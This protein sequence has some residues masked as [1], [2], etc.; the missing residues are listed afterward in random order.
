[1]LGRTLYHGDMLLLSSDGLHG[2]LDTAAIESVLG[3]APDVRSAA[4]TLV[5]RALDAGSRD[6]V[7][8][9]VVQFEED[10]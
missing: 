5:D 6:N 2:V 8:A 1:L 4:Q 9:L 7:T 10:R 3:E